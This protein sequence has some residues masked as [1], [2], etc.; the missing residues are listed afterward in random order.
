MKTKKSLILNPKP[1]NMKRLVLLCIAAL[2]TLSVAGQN[3]FAEYGYTPKIATLSKGQFNEFHDQDT[4]VQIGSVLYNTRSKEIVAF[5]ETDTVY[6]EATLQPDIVSRWI[7]PDPLAD[8][9]MSH[10]PYNFV[11]NNPV[12]YIDPDGRDVILSDAFRSLFIQSFRIFK[13]SDLAKQLMNT[14]ASTSRGDYYNSTNGTLSRHTL[15]FNNGGDWVT[16]TAGG[17]LTS[18]YV[19]NSKGGWDAYNE[20][21]Q[22]TKGSVFKLQMNIQGGLFEDGDKKGHMAAILNHEAFLWGNVYTSWIEKWEK[23]GMSDDKLKGLFGNLAH[24]KRYAGILN[25]DSDI[26]K[27]HLSTLDYLKNQVMNSSGSESGE[28]KDLLQQ[29]MGAREKE[30]DTMGRRHGGNDK[31]NSYLKTVQ[32]QHNDI[33]NEIK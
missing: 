13:Q 3:P 26:Q 25:P 14:W 4:V 17:G 16:W 31:A 9:Y 11:L 1:S 7:S 30:I 15:E 2:W 5:V 8:K 12:I 22:I 20:S 28:W 10:S 32:Q 27:A 18:L 19:Q 29:Y 6:S 33:L 24:G 21:T 23:G